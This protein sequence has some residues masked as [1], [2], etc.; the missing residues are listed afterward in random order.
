[1]RGDREKLK[2]R[3]LST[4]VNALSARGFNVRRL[5]EPRPTPEVVALK[6]QLEV[7]A[8]LP[9]VLIVEAVFPYF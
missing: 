2:H 3:S 8:R 4:Y 1:M 7:F 6:P 9:A 5:V